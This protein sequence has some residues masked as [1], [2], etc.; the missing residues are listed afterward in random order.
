MK[1]KTSRTANVSW[2][3]R[4]ICA[5]TGVLLACLLL[6]S[7]FSKDDT[8]ARKRIAKKWVGK[9]KLSATEIQ[10]DEFLSAAAKFGDTVVKHGRDVYGPKHTPLFVTYLNRELLK[11]P[12][13]IPQMRV[14]QGCSGRTKRDD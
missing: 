6:T 3:N 4:V 11:S 13:K 1:V 7:A 14:D 8:V 12:A 9:K 2:G 5:L 10:K